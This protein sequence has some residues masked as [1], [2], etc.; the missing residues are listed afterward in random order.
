MLAQR[1]L[2]DGGADSFGSRNRMFT[3]CEKIAL[4]IADC[5]HTGMAKPG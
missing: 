5:F 1:P 4:N 3:L 2:D